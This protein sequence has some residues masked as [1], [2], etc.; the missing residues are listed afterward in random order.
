M[1]RAYTFILAVI[2]TTLTPFLSSAPIDCLYFDRILFAQDMIIEWC[3]AILISFTLLTS[4]LI[5]PLI[6]LLRPNEGVS[7]KLTVSFLVSGVV[8]TVFYAYSVVYRQL[9]MDYALPALTFAWLMTHAYVYLVMDWALIDL[10]KVGLMVKTLDKNKAK[11]VNMLKLTN[12]VVALCFVVV[13][14]I[15]W[16]YQNPVVC[17][18]GALTAISVSVVKMTLM[19][20]FL[21]NVLPPHIIRIC[22]L[23]LASKILHYSHCLVLGIGLLSTGYSRRDSWNSSVCNNDLM[24]LSV[25]VSIVPKLAYYAVF[26]Y[27]MVLLQRLRKPNSVASRVVGSKA[28]DGNS[29]TRKE[30]SKTPPVVASVESSLPAAG[31]INDSKRHG[32]AVIISQ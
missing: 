6:L 21:E 8:H 16:V 29:K 11:K 1:N 31:T 19:R 28:D 12:G 25:A 26:S 17:I 3:N 4:D 23:L 27:L 10:I 13:Y 20:M 18:V 30:L 22:N 9:V 14:I 24:L 32:S 7:R 2:I 15:N 5:L